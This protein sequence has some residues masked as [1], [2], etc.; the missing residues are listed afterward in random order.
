VSALA[1]ISERLH[2][3]DCALLI[4]IIGR[5]AELERTRGEAAAMDML[6]TA[7]ARLHGAVGRA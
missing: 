2:P 6:E 7:I 5:V 1:Q 4:R 3:A